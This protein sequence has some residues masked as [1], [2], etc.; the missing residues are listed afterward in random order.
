[1]QAHRDRRGEGDADRAIISMLVIDHDGLWSVDE[2]VREI[3]GDT[4]RV[5]DALARL[6]AAGMIHRPIEGFV[7]ATRSAAF[8]YALDR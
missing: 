2:V 7:A 3:G 5:E 1:M 6:F 8:A 4:V